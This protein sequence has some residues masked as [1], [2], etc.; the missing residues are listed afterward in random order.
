MSQNVSM[1]RSRLNA[2]AEKSFI[3]EDV[4]ASFAKAYTSRKN[5]ILGEVE[6]FDERMTSDIYYRRRFKDEYIYRSFI[7]VLAL[8]SS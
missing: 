8:I 6:S 5:K 7:I 4:E 2:N 3:D 1:N